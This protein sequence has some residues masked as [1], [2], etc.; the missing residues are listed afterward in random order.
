MQNATP[1][2]KIVLPVLK[3]WGR[4]F[5]LTECIY[6]HPY[7][8]EGFQEA[9]LRLYGGNKSSKSVFR[10]MAIPTLR[11][12][13]LIIGY[14]DDIR[15]SANGSLLHLAR[16]EKRADG[17]R[18]LR[19]LLVEIDKSIG[20]LAYLTS[21]PT[22]SL[23]EFLQEWQ[24]RVTTTKVRKSTGTKDRAA[25]E[26]LVD[27]ISFL[28]FSEILYKSH[29]YMRID[30]VVLAKTEEDLD[31]SIKEKKEHFQSILF[32][33]YKKAV[34]VQKGIGTVE[35]DDLRRETSLAMYKKHKVILT[36]RQFDN[37][38][39]DLPKTSDHYVITL[40]RSMGADEKLYLFQ[41]KYYQT[42]FVRFLNK[43]EATHG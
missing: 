1:D 33:S 7:D 18:V 30:D 6:D 24:S 37:L 35:L 9:V 40:G 43:E 38:L 25:H 10:G 29:E 12:L 19:A 26:R 8:R 16:N 36:E 21:K 11:N 23:S 41:G 32:N 27:W 4:I 2:N 15:A 5:E 34:F 28:S 31:T 20:V 14:G 3:A 13:G 39:S 22:I 42:M 17:Y